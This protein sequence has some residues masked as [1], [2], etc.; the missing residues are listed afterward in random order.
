MRDELLR[1]RGSL[2]LEED[3]ARLVLDSLRGRAA[4][5]ALAEAPPRL[6]CGTFSQSDVRTS[7]WVGSFCRYH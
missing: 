2:N 5:A 3:A 6:G 4:E 7:M 1:I